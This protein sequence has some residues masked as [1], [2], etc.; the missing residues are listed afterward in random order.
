MNSCW[1]FSFSL[2]KVRYILAFSPLP[3]A[4]RSVLTL[5]LVALIHPSWWREERIGTKCKLWLGLLSW[6]CLVSLFIEPSAR[7]PIFYIQVLFYTASIPELYMFLALVL[8]SSYRTTSPCSFS[9]SRR[10]IK[11]Y[12][13]GRC[14][15]QLGDAQSRQ[16]YFSVLLSFSNMQL[17]QGSEPCFLWSSTS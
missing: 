14:L 17:C 7:R 13:I 6:H 8:F 4:V 1:R 5:L 12:L 9:L 15:T 3:L 11:A 10:Q 2:N 16:L